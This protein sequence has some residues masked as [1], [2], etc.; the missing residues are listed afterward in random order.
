MKTDA[1]C[2]ACISAEAALAAVVI[3]GKAGASV[4][5][6]GAAYVEAGLDPAATPSVHLT[7]VHRAAAAA[8]GAG[9]APFERARGV[10]RDAARRL[11]QHAERE[12]AGGVDPAARFAIA[13]RWAAAATHLDPR[14]AGLGRELPDAE[15]LA[16]Q[17][18]AI[19]GGPLAVDDAALA[20]DLVRR[21]RNVL[22]V[23]DGIGELSLDKLLIHELLKH[24]RRIYSAV[25]G[26]PLG[27]RATVDDLHRAG[28][29]DLV[30][31]ILPVG[32]GEIGLVWEEATADLKG[33]L[34]VVDLIVAKGQANVYVLH[35]REKEILKPLF[36]LFRTQCEPVAEVFGARGRV[37]VLKVW[38]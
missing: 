19:A 21:A 5:A 12:I 24:C 4:G 2:R 14:A 17:V 35:D 6:A 9:K 1:R 36:C 30:A 25:A 34:E 23:H 32:P 7:H 10:I 31:E 29:A 22:F 3:G 16:A 8:V 18:I 11:V 13:S 37:T 28:I 38:K 33:K 27:G 26:A 20:F 15:A